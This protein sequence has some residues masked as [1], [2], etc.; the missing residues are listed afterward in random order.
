MSCRLLLTQKDFVLHRNFIQST[1]HLT[2]DSNMNSL[3]SVKIDKD[4]EPFRPNTNSS[5]FS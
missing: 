3:S 4:W 2:E 5:L 1:S